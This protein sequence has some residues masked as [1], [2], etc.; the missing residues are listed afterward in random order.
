MLLYMG[1]ERHVAVSKNTLTILPEADYC[2]FAIASSVRDYRLCWHLNKALRINMAREDD[3]DMLYKQKG[4]QAQ[5]SCFIFD[6]FDNQ[7]VYALLQNRSAGRHLLPEL[8]QF[9]F[10]LKIEGLLLYN[11]EANTQQQLKSIPVI[12]MALKQPADT[13]KN[14]QN[15]TLA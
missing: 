10:L 15:L 12:Q 13:L 14:P 1:N 5:F 6:D 8:K 4:R 7:L 3:I 11:E 2:L 9:D